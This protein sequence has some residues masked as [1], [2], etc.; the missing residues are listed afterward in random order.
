MYRISNENNSISGNHDLNDKLVINFSYIKNNSTSGTSNQS[1]T[2]VKIIELN[3]DIIDTINYNDIKVKN[4]FINQAYY[5]NFDKGNKKILY[6]R[7]KSIVYNINASIR[8]IMSDDGLDENNNIMIRFKD[9]YHGLSNGNIT[10]ISFNNTT[11]H[12][13]TTNKINK[14]KY[15]DHDTNILI[16]NV[17]DDEEDS[18]SIYNSRIPVYNNFNYVDYYKNFLAKKNKIH[19][20]DIN[21]TSKS[22]WELIS[23]FNCLSNAEVI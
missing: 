7:I 16:D 1:Y 2:T 23:K 22:T 20:I 17:E 11:S 19:T 14:F 4:Y 21:I 13:I 8:I 3:Y 10:N 6:V 12:K 18:S 5:V 15:I 9:D